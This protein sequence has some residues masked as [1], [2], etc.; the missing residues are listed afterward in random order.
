MRRIGTAGAGAA[1]ALSL[2]AFAG[3]GQSAGAA[4]EQAEEAVLRRKAVALCT[5]PIDFSAEAG[6]GQARS[7]E[8]GAGQATIS[9]YGPIYPPA[10]P[11]WPGPDGTVRLYRYRY[12]VASGAWAA[13]QTTKSS[14]FVVTHTHI[15]ERLAVFVQPYDLKGVRRTPTEASVVV[16]PPPR[17]SSI[18]AVAP[19]EYGPA[20]MTPEP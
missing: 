1:A 18:T 14:Q 7:G 20:D 8:A 5:K 16:K 3:C 15:G 4:R 6:S 13:W 12:H 10:P 2:G 17:T 9:W 11:Q 19:C